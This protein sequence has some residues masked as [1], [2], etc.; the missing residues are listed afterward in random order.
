MAYVSRLRAIFTIIFVA[1]AFHAVPV[2]AQEG[3][4]GSRQDATSSRSGAST[5]RGRTDSGQTDWAIA[6]LVRIDSRI[7]AIDRQITQATSRTSSQS[8]IDSASRALTELKTA[9]GRACN[10]PPEARAALSATLLETV[11]A[12]VN[13]S[14]SLPTSYPWE[15]FS[16]EE[17]Q[18]LCDQPLLAAISSMEAGIAAMRREL[19]ASADSVDDLEREK[20]EQETRKQEVITQMSN[21]VAAAR[22]AATMPWILVIIF[23][24]GVVMLLGARLFSPAIQSELVCSGQLVQFATILILFGA[25]IALGLA[26]KLQEQTLAALLGGL[27]GYVLSQGIGQ[28]DQR[29]TLQTIRTMAGQSGQ[30]GGTGGSAPDRPGADATAPDQAGQPGGAQSA[31]SPPAAEAGGTGD[32]ATGTS[33]PDRR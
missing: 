1:I 4:K 12:L 33:G 16:A 29:S 8:T 11:T 21:G 23:T 10:A 17:L 3:T 6:E 32:P 30:P 7:R 28:K 31:R 9:P 15:A 5:T 19:S 24:M 25:L 20:A 13:I 2:E 14:S 26:D 18:L 22:V 27:A